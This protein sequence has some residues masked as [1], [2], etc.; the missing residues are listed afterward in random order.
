MKRYVEWYPIFVML[1]I[2]FA[3]AISNILLKKIIMDGMNHLVFIT[4]RQSV[5][6]IFLAPIA[7]FLERN[8]RPKLTS[9]ILCYLFL[10]AIVGASLTQYLFLLGIQYTSATF[11]CAFVNMVPVITFLMALPF[12]LETINTKDRSGRAKVIGTLICLGGALLLT[13]YK[14]IPL[15]HFSDQQTASQSM[16]EH[17]SSSKRKE[18]WIFGSLIL[19]AGTLL[20]SS[21]FL[22]QSNIGKKYP[23]Q[24]SSTVIMT[25]FSAIQSAILTFS[26]NRRLSIWI[27]KE[28][29]DML[30]VIYTGL[31][32][33]GLC[34]VGMSWCVK[35]RGPV[36][37]AAFS[38]LVQV[39]AAM[40]DVPF[41]H[42]QLNLGSVMGSVIVIVGLYFL[43]WGK[44]KEIQKVPQETAEKKDK[45]LRFQV[46]ESND[47]RAIP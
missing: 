21:W 35:K 14:G 27:P 12:G 39:M 8:T 33:S 31:I 28:M 42:E 29:I 34:Y 36:F 43:L 18:R 9:R 17:N 46:H 4:Y 47:E 16:E 5:S 45:E 11:A 1:S 15:I 20:W 23:C 26:I 30:S 37:T 2:D 32:G 6:T 10:S 19:F 3:F 24:Y 22:L 40:L 44:T 41:L 38:P 13:F 25:F 7:F